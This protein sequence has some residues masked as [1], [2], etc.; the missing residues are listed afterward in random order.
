MSFEPKLNKPLR[1]LDLCSLKSLRQ[2][3]WYSKS[4]FS[5]RMSMLVRHHFLNFSLRIILELELLEI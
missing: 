2:L 5:A 1:S 3:S 4:D